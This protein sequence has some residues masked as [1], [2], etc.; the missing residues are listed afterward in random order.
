M[1]LRCS[2]DIDWYSLAYEQF[3]CERSSSD[4]RLRYTNLLQPGISRSTWRTE[5]E[6]RLM[7]L[8]K[9]HGMRNW[10]KVA[11]ELG[12]RRS[13]F[14]C[15]AHYQK[16]LNPDFLK[17]LV[18]YRVYFC[19][20]I[21]ILQSIFLLYYYILQGMCGWE[22]TCTVVLLVYYR[23]NFCYTISILQGMC[24]R[25]GTCTVVCVGMYCVCF[26]ND[27]DS[28]VVLFCYYL[29]YLPLHG[30]STFLS[31]CFSIV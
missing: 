24:G 20:T 17:R 28:C 16:A 23:V 22:G 10:A 29:K 18:Y 15:I 26:L 12:S 13:L 7:K 8:V 11:A 5:E 19:S 2:S 14:Q 27:T 3:V 25:E 6:K 30:E 4:C 9:K 31:C 21:S 1:L